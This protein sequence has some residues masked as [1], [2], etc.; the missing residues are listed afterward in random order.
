[1]YFMKLAKK[2]PEPNK[3]LNAFVKFAV[4]VGVVVA[5]FLVVKYICKKHG[6]KSAFS[7]PCGCG[8]DD[9]ECE[10]GCSDEDESYN[11]DDECD[12]EDAC[13]CDSIDSSEENDEDISVDISEEE[14]P[15]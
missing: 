5:V 9:D 4:F 2:E 6:I 13:C 7:N 1:M 14:K 8:C 11:E 12:C 3:T 15:D 10:C